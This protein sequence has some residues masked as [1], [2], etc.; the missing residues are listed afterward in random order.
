[1]LQ[2]VHGFDVDWTL[3][4]PAT[5]NVH[6]KGCDD[7]ILW[8]RDLCVPTKLQKLHQAGGRI[9][10]F[11]NQQGDGP[12]GLVPLFYSLI[13]TILCAQGVLTVFIPT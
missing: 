5:G 9:V 4:Q 7:W 6:P 1:V 3:I 8:N 11:S 2:V 10:L 13:Y 12:F